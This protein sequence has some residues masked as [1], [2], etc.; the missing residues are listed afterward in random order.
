MTMITAVTADG[1]KIDFESYDAYIK[2][3]TERA[4]KE[5]EEKERKEKEEREERTKKLASLTERQRE[6]ID[7]LETEIFLIKMS[8]D[9]LNQKDYQSINDNR[10]KIKEIRGF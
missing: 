7:K 1:E 4:K 9:F 6:E 2:W 3:D 5:R 10:R 8:T